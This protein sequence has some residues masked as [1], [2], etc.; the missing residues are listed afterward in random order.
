MVKIKVI[1]SLEELEITGDALGMHWRH[2][3]EGVRK[4]IEGIQGRVE[5][6]KMEIEK[7]MEGRKMNDKT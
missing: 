4:V 1:F 6:A 7:A 3:S 2:S 5:G